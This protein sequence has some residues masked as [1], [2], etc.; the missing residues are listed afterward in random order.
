MKK[1]ATVDE[2]AE[3]FNRQPEIILRFTTLPEF[4]KP[5]SKG[6][7]NTA[8]VQ[9]FIADNN[10]D[11]QA[12]IKSYKLE[13]DALRSL[14]TAQATEVKLLLAQEEVLYVED[15]KTIIESEY[16]IIRSRFR[17]LSNTLSQ[18]LLQSDTTDPEIVSKIIS[19]A[20]DVILCELS[21]S[22]DI[23]DIYKSEK[24]KMED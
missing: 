18:K 24:R 13:N 2:L 6:K 23:V 22:D 19:D 10:S 8:L 16:S 5:T 4:P 3:M 17:T 14:K 7:Y 9:S 12:S 15:I 21:D 20:V 1:L 11:I